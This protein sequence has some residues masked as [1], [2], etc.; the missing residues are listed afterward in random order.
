[1]VTGTVQAGGALGILIPPSIIFIIYG[2]LA[3]VS[4]GHLWLAGVLPGIMLATMYILYIAIRCYRNP[5]L[6]PALPPEVKVTW[7]KRLRVLGSGIAPI[8]I[9]F[10]VLGLL[11][12]GV[13]T[14]M[15]CAA[16]GALGSIIAAVIHRRLTW[17]L[18]RETMRE[19]LRT[20]CLF[21]W[22]V[23]AALLFSA[24]FDGLGA[25]HVVEPLLARLGG[26]YM[27]LMG[28]MFSWIIMGAIMDDTA[29]L[30]IVCPI[31]IPIVLHLGFDLVWFGVLY[32]VNC[33]MAYITPPF[34]YN[35]FILK[36]IA[37]PEIKLADIYRSVIPF[38]IIQFIALLVIIF[39]PQIALWLPTLVYGKAIPGL[40]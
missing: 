23:A 38:V 9:I 22:I 31:Y 29:M 6:G 21:L 13:T 14:L 11:F 5:H 17:N 20:T 25:V 19:T 28:M 27:I 1:M 35:L 18:L 24:V 37:P 2:M 40:Y 7:G 16:I 32:V 30:I 8:I 26:R 12:M 10:A 39:V 34:G 3:R 4:V 33:Q 15:E 36:G